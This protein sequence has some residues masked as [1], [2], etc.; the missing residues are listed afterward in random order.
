MSDR[1]KALYKTHILEKAKDQTHVGELANATH[2]VEAYNPLCGDQFKLYLKVEEGFVKKLKF[3]GYGCSISKASTAV[4][5]DKLQGSSIDDFNAIWAEFSELV[6]EDSNQ[7]PE[8]ISKDEYLLAF[9]AARE[10]PERKTC[11]TLGWQALAD[12]VIK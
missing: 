8:D 4:L 6:N 11:A 1:I 9:A 10:F 3:S 5:A 2:V 7:K 12:A